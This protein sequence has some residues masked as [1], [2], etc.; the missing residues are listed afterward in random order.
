MKKFL[1]L[2]ISIMLSLPSITMAGKGGGTA[3]PPGAPWPMFMNNSQ[4]NGQSL[5]V[6]PNVGTL[7]WTVN[8]GLSR[9]SVWGDVVIGQDET[10]YHA[11]SL[12]DSGTSRYYS[13]IVAYNPDGTLKWQTTCSG[14]AAN[15]ATIAIDPQGVIYANFKNW[16]CAV[17][18]SGNVIWETDL[19]YTQA[20]VPLMTI[21]KDRTIYV[22]G[23]D[24]AAVNPDGTIKWWFYCENL[25]S[26]VALSPKEDRIY[27]VTG[28]T[29]TTDALLALD[30]NGNYL[31]E[32]PLG[33][34][35]FDDFYNPIAVGSDGIIY[36]SSYKDSARYLHA[37]DPSRRIQKWEYRIVDVDTSA[38]TT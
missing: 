4:H 20:R 5:Y 6:G 3:P 31:W 24:I 22:G 32:F 14:S 25:C 15:T 38:I 37:I 23:Y 18:Q 9:D 33:Y 13:A 19:G 27:A 2:A 16:L 26:S 21:A 11:G 30:T 8:T 35:G 10:I 34:I 1:V 12:Y 17:D 28:D 36:V 29:Y 7:K